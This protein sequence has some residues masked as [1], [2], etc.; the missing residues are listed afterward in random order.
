MSRARLTSAARED[1]TEI[2]DIIRVDSPT[3]ARR[4]LDELRSAVQR[5]SRF[6]KI[7][8]LRE[9]LTSEPLR[10]WPVYSYLIVYRLTE[11]VEIVRILHGA[12][13]VARLLMNA[14]DD[15]E[16]PKESGQG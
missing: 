3:A 11:P 5:L 12:R 6:P 2:I 8:H 13:D 15:P 7:G 9:D 16:P 1:L 14:E 10:F 4:V